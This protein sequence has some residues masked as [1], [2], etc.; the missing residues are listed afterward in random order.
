MKK[1]TFAVCGM[2][3]RGTR[4]A[5]ESLKY[6][7]EMEVTAI[8]DTRRVRLDAAN[9]QLN[10]PEDRL[11]D[12][13]DSLLAA[14]RMAEIMVIATQDG[15]HKEHA[16]AAMKKGYHLLLEKPISNKLEDCIEIAEAAKKYDRRVIVCHVLRY[17]GFYQEIKKM[18]NQGLIGDVMNIHACEMV[19]YYHF[20][21]SFVRGNWHKE[22][23]TSPMILAKCCHD[24][25]L[26]LW[27]SGKH[28]EAVSSIGELT[29]FRRECCPEGAKE[30]CSDGCE[31]DCPYHAPKF[32]LSRMPGWPTHV[33]HPEPTEENIMEILRTGDYGRC[34]YQMDNDVADHQSVLL[35]MEDGVTISFTVSAFN[36]IQNREIHVMGTKG[37]IWG[38]FRS[39]KLHVVL[40]GEEPYE[41][42]L[43]PLFPEVTG[44]GGGDT[45]MV[46]DVIRLFRGDDFDQSGITSIDRSV[47]SHLVAFA[48]EESRRRGGELVQ[49]DSFR[50]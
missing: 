33:L 9:K 40:Y 34:V 11:F 48:A 22:A 3:N 16:I 26:M 2:G 4:Y 20:A 36:H 42:D 7:D 44:H 46:Y 39:K 28:C 35:R 13:A 17:T 8:A 41:I 14:P 19:A 23:D 29:H 18:I 50:K 12:G 27:L 5:M 31:V 47:E 38:D 49:M 10:L 1:V 45:R 37:H 43:A 25:D 21:H 32:Y 6:H 30:R 24:M 15:Q